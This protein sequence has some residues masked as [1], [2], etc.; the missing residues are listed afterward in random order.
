LQKADSQVVEDEL[1]VE[2]C[3]DQSGKKQR[4]IELV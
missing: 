1:Y 2:V 4:I 3:V